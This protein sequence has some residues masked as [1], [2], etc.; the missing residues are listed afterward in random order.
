VSSGVNTRLKRNDK[1]ILR[2]NRHFARTCTAVLAVSKDI[3]EQVEDCAGEHRP[4]VEFLPIY[5]RIEF[6]GVTAP[7]DNRSCRVL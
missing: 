2:L 4:I 5:R 6:D 7:D 1:L 3:S